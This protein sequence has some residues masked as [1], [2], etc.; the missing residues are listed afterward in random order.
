MDGLNNIIT[1]ITKKFL[2]NCNH[3][4][5]ALNRVLLYGKIAILR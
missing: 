4:I 2:K 3:K 1:K 5:Q